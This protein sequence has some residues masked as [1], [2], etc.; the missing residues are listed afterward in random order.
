[1][2]SSP[3]GKVLGLQPVNKEIVRTSEM[4][5]RSRKQEK[6]HGPD[7]VR[8]PRL[9]AVYRLVIRETGPSLA[10]KVNV[11]GICYRASSSASRCSTIHEQ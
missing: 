11:A 3:I 9:E 5:L 1:M 2:D 6:G 10:I 7:E 8:P 4:Y